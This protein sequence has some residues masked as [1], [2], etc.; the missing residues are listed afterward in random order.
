MISKV[1]A[2]KDVSKDVYFV[3]GKMFIKK[4]NVV[5]SLSDN[6]DPEVFYQSE[7]KSA[8]IYADNQTLVIGKEMAIVVFR[9][10]NRKTGIVI[11]VETNRWVTLVH[12]NGIL[13][14]CGG[15]E[16]GTV[17]NIGF[18]GKLIWQFDASEPFVATQSGA[19]TAVFYMVESKDIVA[20]SLADGVKLWHRTLQELY[21]EAVFIFPRES[22]NYEGKIF[23]SARPENDPGYT[24]CLDAKT[25]KEIARFDCI[26]G[27]LKGFGEELYSLSGWRA[28]V[29]L[30]MNTFSTVTW[31]FEELLSPL[32]IKLNDVQ[33]FVTEDGLF[34][35]TDGF[36][37]PKNRI[38]IIDLH[39][40]KLIQVE[41]IQVHEKGSHNIMKLKRLADRVC[42]HTSDNA[43]HIYQME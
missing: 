37:I 18:D 33:F 14:R 4:E 3:W 16:D 1:C 17:K 23:F 30:N 21:A 13:I 41:E 9:E 40:N 25:G 28:L 2:K 6:L 12:E 32:N 29:K 34:F 11:P 24:F 22:V 36:I 27:L 42:V 15:R 20:Y 26:T 35:F 10:M 7:D 31:D 38:G 43:L 19:D 8:I 5:F 39:K